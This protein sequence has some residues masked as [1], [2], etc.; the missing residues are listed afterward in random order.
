MLIVTFKLRKKSCGWK[1]I[2]LNISDSKPHS[3][4]NVLFEIPKIEKP[5]NLYSIV[6]ITVINAL[7]T[8]KYFVCFYDSIYSLICLNHFHKLNT[9]VKSRDS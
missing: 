1:K 8:E 2:S 9:A 6:D 3:V 4:R 7:C 5:E